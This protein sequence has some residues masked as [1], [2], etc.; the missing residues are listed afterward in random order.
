MHPACLDDGEKRVLFELPDFS[1]TLGDFA[2]IWL[3]VEL[4]AFLGKVGGVL[5]SRGVMFFVRSDMVAIL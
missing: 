2:C 4:L 5:G 1:R 3:F